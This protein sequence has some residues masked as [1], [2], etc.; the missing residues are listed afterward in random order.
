[1]DGPRRAA[2]FAARDPVPRE[3]LAALV[4]T[5]CNLDARIE[6]ISAELRL[7]PYALVFVAG[8][9][10]L[11][12]RPHFAAAIRAANP[13]ET[14]AA[15]TQELTPTEMAALCAIA[16]LPPATR[17]EISRMA[18]RTVSRDVIGRSKR[19]GLVDGAMRA[20][21]PGA[22]FA[23][24][25]TRK[26]LEAFGLVSLRDLPDLD[27]LEGEGL[28]RPTMSDAALDAALGVGDDDPESLA[29]DRD[30]PW[31]A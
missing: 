31:S 13:G 22:P 16:Y 1:M 26:F 10:Q 12:T 28:L 30:E 4:G 24:V 17:A 6:D 8:G 9:W 20:P 3:T 29:D 5:R 19:L 27:R 15:G 18:G 7:R 23:Y 11:R 2:I 14:R 25:T 21:E